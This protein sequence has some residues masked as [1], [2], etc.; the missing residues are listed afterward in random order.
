MALLTVQAISEAGAALTY[1]A[2]A[3]GGDTFVN[4]DD[5]TFLH[6]KNGSASSV[7]VTVT[8]QTTSTNVPGFGPVTK[9]NQVVAVPANGDRLIGPLP[10]KAFNNPANSQVS[11][12]YSATTTVTVAVVRVP[13]L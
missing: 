13:A 11:V 2:A 8:A 1:A 5:R 7:N 10:T 12:S 3:S 4:A 6:V 9:A